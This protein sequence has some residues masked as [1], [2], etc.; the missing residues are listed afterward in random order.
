MLQLAVSITVSFHSVHPFLFY[1]CA[2]RK[3]RRPMS[4]SPEQ[5]EQQHQRLQQQSQGAEMS[6][7]PDTPGENGVSTLPRYEEVDGE[8]RGR[9]FSWAAPESAYRPDKSWYES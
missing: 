9:Q 6:P 3:I 4:P 5:Q 1:T 8:A 7:V 2:K